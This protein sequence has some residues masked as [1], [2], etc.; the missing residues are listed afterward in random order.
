M[1]GN[2]EEE[3]EEGFLDYTTSTA[4]ESFCAEI[5][6]KLRSW[7]ERAD[8]HCGTSTSTLSRSSTHGTTVTEA[9]NGQA[10]DQAIVSVLESKL[11]QFRPENYSLAL[12]RPPEGHYLA[13]WLG[14][15]TRV[16]EPW[17]WNRGL[18]PFTAKVGAK[19]IA[20]GCQ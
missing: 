20:R 12:H 11:P 1:E 19:S 3:E 9:E 16:A 8:A 10:I 6:A 7:K 14:L 4:W 13:D 18:V 17:S 15:G 2:E 5:E